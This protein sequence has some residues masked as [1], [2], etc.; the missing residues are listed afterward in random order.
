MQSAWHV[1]FAPLLPLFF[2]FAFLL[3]SPQHSTQHAC[4]RYER[5]LPPDLQ[6]AFISPF[7]FVWSID[8]T[9]AFAHPP[10]C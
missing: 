9:A 1:P 3:L 4:M 10:P 2:Y 7:Q 5:S 6:D 8:T